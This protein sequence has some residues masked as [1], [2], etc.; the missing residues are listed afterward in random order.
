MAS[1]QRIFGVVRLI[2][3]EA[4]GFAPLSGD[5][6]ETTIAFANG[7]TARLFGRDAR[8]AALTELLK[9]ASAAQVP[10]MVELDSAGAEV[11]DVRVP[12]PSDGVSSIFEANAQVLEVE[13]VLSQARHRLRRDN[14]LMLL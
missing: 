5:I 4:A 9:E 2:G 1:P 13:L 6:V 7:R 14:I 3:D 10:V 11:A 12:L 8:S